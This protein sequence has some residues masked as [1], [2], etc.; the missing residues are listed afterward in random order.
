MKMPP[1]FEAAFS[2]QYSQRQDRVF[3]PETPHLKVGDS[4]SSINSTGHSEGWQS[5][6]RALL[7]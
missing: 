2:F 6:D 5:F 7:G 3:S 4:T 1:V